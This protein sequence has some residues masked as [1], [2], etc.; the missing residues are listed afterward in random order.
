MCRPPVSSALMI[1]AATLIIA[2][3]LAPAAVADPPV[4]VPVTQTS[5]VV[6]TDLCAFPITQEPTVTFDEVF[7]TGTD[8]AFAHVVEQ[9]V[10]SANGKSL[11]SSPYAF[12]V[13]ATVDS[14]GNITAVQVNGIVVKVP[15]PDGSLFITSGRYVRENPTGAPVFFPDKGGTVNLAGFCSA[16]AP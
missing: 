13:Q 10:F 11:T 2:V 6:V 1:T 7:F 14:N 9:D 3:L 4:R 12:N 8:R 5:T 15:L 16:L